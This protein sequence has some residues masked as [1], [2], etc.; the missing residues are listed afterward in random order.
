MANSSGVLFGVDCSHHQEGF[1]VG[2]LRPHG[3]EFIIARTAQAAGNKLDGKTYG[4]VKDRYYATHKRNAL[5]AGQLFSSYFYV[6]DRLAPE[7]N[8][9]L[10]A[11]VEPDRSIPV[12]LDWED[13]SGGGNFLR[14]VTAAFV[15]AGYHVWGVYAPN[16]YWKAKGQPSLDGLPPLI[17]SKYANMVPEPLATKYANTSESGW[18]S[19]G[20]NTVHMLQFT[21]TGRVGG[22]PVNLDLDAFKGTRAELE[23]WWY[24]SAIPTPEPEGDADVALIRTIT[25]P[26]SSTKRTEYLRS[27]PGGNGCKLV[28]KV[29]GMDWNT[30]RAEATV[31][32]GNVQAFGNDNA[33]IGHDPFYGD[34][35]GDRGI[36]FDREI[37]LPGALFGSI[38]YSCD[39]D[40]ELEIYG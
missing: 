4:T 19:Y 3:I 20:G 17:N 35:A 12:M 7:A 15:A 39:Q 13:G 25:L 28:I 29:P 5:A 1:N 6:G 37:P 31:W 9:E 40:F 2:A 22:Y 26:A 14:L 21:S 11:S 16:W 24:D 10:H 38:D 23:A 34:P 36:V 8:V 32:L 27:L 33:G 18:D 30:H